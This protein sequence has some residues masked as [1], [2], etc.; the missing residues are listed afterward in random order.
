LRG[1]FK[2]KENATQNVKDS[3][4]E[5]AAKEQKAIQKEEKAAQKV[6]DKA[7]EKMEEEQKTNDRGPK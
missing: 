5:K 6:K 2:K 4:A 1:Y 7:E 3:T